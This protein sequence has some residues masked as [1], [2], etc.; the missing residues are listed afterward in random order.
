MKYVAPVAAGLGVDIETAAA[1]TG[2]LGDAGIQGSMAGTSLRSI[3]GRLAEPPAAAA[4][5]LAKLNIQTKDAKGNLR[6]LPDILTEL[7]KKTTKTGNAQRAGIFKAIAGEEAFSAL[8]VLAER[9][10]TGELQKLIKELKNAQ[11]EAR[12]VADT[13]TNNLDGD[14]KSLSSAWE[15]IGIQ[16]IAVSN[17]NAPAPV[18]HFLIA[19]TFIHDGR[20]RLIC[21]YAENHAIPELATPTIMVLWI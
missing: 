20:T 9:A 11:G 6:A 19:R 2:K 13:M 12:K 10:G 16:M 17:N 1:A 18:A 7:D 15:D 8:S 5:V 14:M 3:L 4:K 21:L